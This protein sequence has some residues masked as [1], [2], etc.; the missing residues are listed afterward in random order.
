[1]YDEL[2]RFCGATCPP[3]RN[4]RGESRLRNRFL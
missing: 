4:D 2:S 1:M 3:R